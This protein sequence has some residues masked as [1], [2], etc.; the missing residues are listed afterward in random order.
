LACTTSSFGR[1]DGA[2][3][4]RFFAERLAPLDAGQGMAA[5]AELLVPGLVGPGAG[6]AARRAATEVMARVPEA[7]YRRALAAIAGFDR[8]QAL[9][10]IAV[11]TLCLA[12]EHDRTAAPDVMQRMAQRIPKADYRCLPD[13]GHIANV[14]QPEAFN[15]A[16]LAFL[17]QHFDRGDPCTSPATP[18]R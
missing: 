15:A 6:A 1:P 13:A 17:R 10:A 18:P 8:R 16:L 4:A 5:M 9:A 7:S 3:Q 2:W 12:A 11:P 14:E